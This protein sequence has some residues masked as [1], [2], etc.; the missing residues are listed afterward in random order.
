MEV[1]L[2]WLWQGSALTLA[3]ACVLRISR[4]LSATTRC[5]VCWIA[6]VLLLALPALPALVV[7]VP[8]LQDASANTRPAF[9]AVTVPEVPAW[10]VLLIVGCWLTWI[11]IGALRIVAALRALMSTRGEVAPLDPQREAALPHW[12]SVRDTGRRTTVAVSSGVRSA[13]LLG[14]GAPIIAVSPEALDALPSEELDQV[15]VHE[16]AHAQR[17]DDVSRFVQLLICCVA[18]LHPGIWWISRQIDLEREVACDDCAVNVTG[19]PRRMAACLTRL[20]AAAS[21][22]HVTLL[23]PGAAAGSQVTTRVVRLLDPRRNTSTRRFS[24]AI[25]AA[26]PAMVGA[27]LA[28]ASLE[29]TTMAASDDMQAAGT[30]APSPVAA[31]PDAAAS[32]R[33]SDAVGSLAADLPVQTSAPP[34]TPARSTAADRPATPASEPAPPEMAPLSRIDYN[35]FR[36]PD[37]PTPARLLPAPESPR[38]SSHDAAPP[39]NPQGAVQPVATPWGAAADAGIAVG[40]SSKTAATATAGFFSKLGHKIGGSF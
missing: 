8:T 14:L 19:Q 27:A 24:A 23:V 16:W 36:L 4:R 20:A 17:Y 3:L 11:A 40:R 5:Q 9:A 31:A 34:I 6:L 29:M 7:P 28:I 1:L 10:G 13:A 26:A 37:L 30:A 12:V 15:L 18:G 32:V 21:G 35:G 2:N 25:A 38:A 22:G 33:P 39:A